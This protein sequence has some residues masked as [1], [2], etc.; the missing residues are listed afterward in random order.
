MKLNTLSRA[1]P[2]L[3]AS[4][5]RAAIDP[6]A[7]ATIGLGSPISSSY[8]TTA[9]RTP[10]IT[11]SV[12]FNQ[13]YS[14]DTTQFTQWSWRV[15]VT[16][17]D[18]TNTTGVYISP[19]ASADPHIVLTSY[20]LTW[21]GPSA[22]NEELAALSNSSTT[23]TTNDLE[24]RIYVITGDWPSK[25][26]KKFTPNDSGD[27]SSAFGSQ[28]VKSLEDA[29]TDTGFFTSWDSL[30][31]CADTFDAATDRG[32]YSTVI[33]NS[34]VQTNATTNSTTNGD[35]VAYEVSSQIL[36]TN[37]TYYDEA[38]DTLQVFMLSLSGH[39]TLLCQRLSKDKTATSTSD[40]SSA[41]SS[42]AAM[43]TARSEHMMGVG[44]VVAAGVAGWYGLS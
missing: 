17:V 10:N 18:L 19:S 5:A 11:D 30:D 7:I 2:I 29:A 3:L 14:G 22:L 39:N 36:G 28:C 26:L 4:A 20:D 41:T 16:D 24:L 1:A 33:A 15:N 21:T 8:I 31:G 38:V 12:T 9:A 37:T 6:G 43:P 27:C 13:S 32:A 34:T 44:V 40:S 23:S 25:V 35:M 42:S